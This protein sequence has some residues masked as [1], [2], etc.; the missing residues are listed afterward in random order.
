MVVDLHRRRAPHAPRHSTV[1]SHVN[2]PSSLVPPRHN[3]GAAEV[4]DDVVGPPQRAAH[5][6]ADQ[7]VVPPAGLVKY[8]E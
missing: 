1:L 6:D 7:H 5:V 3:P 2:F 8:M 4:G